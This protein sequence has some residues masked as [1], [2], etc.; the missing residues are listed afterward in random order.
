MVFAQNNE[1]SE[2]FI[3]FKQQRISPVIL[4][5]FVIYFLIKKNYQYPFPWECTNPEPLQHYNTD[6]TCMKDAWEFTGIHTQKQLIFK[7]VTLKVNPCL[8]PC[9]DEILLQLSET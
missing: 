5:I 4:T 7:A 8:H 9:W 1:V 6:F 2:Y 3:F